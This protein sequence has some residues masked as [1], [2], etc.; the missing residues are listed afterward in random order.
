MVS[1]ERAAWLAE[2]KTGL[3]ATDSAA[4]CG[5]SPYQSALGVFLDKTGRL[6]ERPATAAMTWGLRLEPVLADAYAEE[7][8][9][10]VRPPPT[11]LRHPD[12]PWMLANPDRL[13]ACGRIVEL[14]T[15][16]AF[17]A[18]AWGA[19]GTDE[20]PE[21]YLVQVAH[22]MA[23]TGLGVT[24]VAVLIGGQDFRV[25]TVRRDERLVG[26]LVEIGAAFWG[27]V[28]RDDPPPPDWAH[29]RTPELVEALYAAEG[30]AVPL[31]AECQE[32]AREYRL[33]D[34]RE[35][36]ARERRAVLKA[37]LT[38]CLGGAG[39]GL[40]PDGGRV[41][42]RKV[43]RKSYSVAATEYYTFTLK[44]PEGQPEEV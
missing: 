29:P 18:D 31:D 34:A 27:R 36:N 19:P 38:A 15:C 21:Y 42:R 32:M 8:G 17:A 3:G 26:R 1:D 30:G 23:V 28:L 13:T 14:K 7:T 40:L 20:V 4:V 22:Q 2:R 44:Q 24:D 11:N 6:P 39:V 25:Y 10:T 12:H 33:L 41:L 5:L 16:S 9:R 35:A 37:R 43:S